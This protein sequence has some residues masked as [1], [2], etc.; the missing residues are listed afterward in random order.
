LTLLS[1]R[2]LVL[3]EGHPTALLSREEFSH[4]TILEYAS[5]GGSVQ[6]AFADLGVAR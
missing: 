6:P 4:E 1:D 3:C 5:P 2:I